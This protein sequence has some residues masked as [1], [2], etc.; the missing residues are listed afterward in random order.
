MVKCYDTQYYNGISY[1]KY[2]YH[3]P[4]RKLEA[5]INYDYGVEDVDDI[6][7]DDE[8]EPMGDGSDTE[9]EPDEDT[10]S[11]TEDDLSDDEDFE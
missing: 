3:G 11:D 9:F 5:P 6:L 2:E 1:D 10:E 7:S 4:T 8:D